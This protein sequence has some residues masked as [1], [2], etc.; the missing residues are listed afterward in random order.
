M[1]ILEEE[2]SQKNILSWL[3]I[4]LKQCHKEKYG[5]SSKIIYKKD[6]KNRE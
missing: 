2:F 1:I 5:E 4:K 6:K 3:E